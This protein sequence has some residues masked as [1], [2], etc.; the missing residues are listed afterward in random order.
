MAV[1]SQFISHL[2]NNEVPL[3]RVQ[4]SWGTFY[5][6]QYLF[7]V[8]WVCQESDVKDCGYIRKK[9]RNELA[10]K[11]KSQNFKPE[12]TVGDKSKPNHLTY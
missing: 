3:Y 2:P 12:L 8:N 7:P 9:K 6:I 10:S 11:P 4:D 1:T 5:F